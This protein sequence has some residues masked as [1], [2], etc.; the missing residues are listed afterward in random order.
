MKIQIL[1]GG[2]AK[3]HALAQHAEAAA[4]DLGLDY[5]MEKIT[6]M[7]RYADFGVAMTPALAVDGV[8]KVVGKV[9]SVDE[10]KTLLKG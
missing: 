3:C 4:K 9:A 1:G 10:I 2:C 8:V 7:N 5:Q 6:D